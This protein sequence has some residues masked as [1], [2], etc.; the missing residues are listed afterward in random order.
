MCHARVNNC[1]ALTVIYSWETSTKYTKIN[2]NSVFHVWWK[3]KIEWYTPGKGCINIAI[4]VT[5]CL[6]KQ[7]FW[8][9]VKLRYGWLLSR[10]PTQ[11][12]CGAQDD[13]QHAL[14]CKGSF[15][16][17]RHNHIRNITAELLSQVTKDVKIDPVPQ[18]LSLT[19]EIST[20]DICTL[21]FFV[22][23]KCSVIYVCVC[24]RPST[25]KVRTTS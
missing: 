20:S 17:L 11:C 14:S 16:T 4:D 8:D 6:N 18:S 9:L 22:R 3:T 5:Y 15:V 25:V 7:E 21:F 10:L 23:L 13:A 19:G 24:L 2:C 12:I 1:Y